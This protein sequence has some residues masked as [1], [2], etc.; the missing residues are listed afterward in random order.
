M[1]SERLKGLD[2]K[3]NK[4]IKNLK[5]HVFVKVIFLNIIQSFSDYPIHMYYMKI[6]TQW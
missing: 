6:N 5:K 1:A 3:I 2:K 4:I